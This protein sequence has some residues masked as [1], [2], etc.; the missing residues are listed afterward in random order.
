MDEIVDQVVQGMQ[1]S[2][3]EMVKLLLQGASVVS[4]QFGGLKQQLPNGVEIETPFYLFAAP[5]LS[6]AILQG[7]SEGITKFQERQKQIIELSQKRIVTQ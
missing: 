7:V 2:L 5:E 1:G 6:A 3:R 4:F